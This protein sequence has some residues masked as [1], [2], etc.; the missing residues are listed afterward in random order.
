MFRFFSCGF[1]DLTRYLVH[2][3]KL[4]E[5]KPHANSLTQANSVFALVLL[6]EWRGNFPTI[7]TILFQTFGHPVHVCPQ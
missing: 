7:W 2:C 5:A 1:C 3:W 4:K 6:S